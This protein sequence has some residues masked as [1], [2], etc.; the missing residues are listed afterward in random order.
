M[1]NNKG[2]CY[3]CDRKLNDRFNRKK[4][5][6]KVYSGMCK[7][8]WGIGR[9][10]SE[11]TRQKISDKNR[12]KKKPPKTLIQRESS[13]MRLLGKRGKKAL[14]WKGGITPLT[15][16]IRQCFKYRQWRSDIFTRDNFTCQV[17][18]LKGVYLEADHYPKRFSTIFHEYKIKSLEKALNCEELWNINNGRTV[19]KK[20][21]PRGRQ[22]KK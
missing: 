10:L 8:C 11:T 20:H 7:R 18:G 2:Y 5:G 16:L 3:K 9:K 15:K 21:N 17:C 6:V 14:N 13:K 4:N 12:G 19:C 22:S 1:K